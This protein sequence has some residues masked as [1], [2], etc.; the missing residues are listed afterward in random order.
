MTVERVEENRRRKNERARQR[1]QETQQRIDA[2][3]AMPEEQRS[4]ADQDFLEK[5]MCSRERKIV[6]DRE[7]RK[8]LTLVGTTTLRDAELK[9]IHVPKTS[10]PI[11]P[12]I[13]LDVNQRAT[14]YMAKVSFIRKENREE[15]ESSSRG[16]EVITD[17]H[18]IDSSRG[19]L[20]P[21]MDP[22]GTTSYSPYLMTYPT[23]SAYSGGNYMPFVPS[24]PPSWSAVSQYSYQPSVTPY[25]D[26]GVEESIHTESV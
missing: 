21:M 5:S 7:R 23:T 12:S 26:L 11:Q 24:G 8:A 4:K 18:R 20:Q 6:C 1:L 9:G 25:I 2:I 3:L 10:V 15:K 19:S 14:E 17:E 22:Y 16:Y 13:D